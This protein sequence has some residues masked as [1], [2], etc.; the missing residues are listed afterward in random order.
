[1]KL[2]RIIE[3]V[4]CRPWMITPSGYEAI[5]KLIDSKL[6]GADVPDFSPGME[7]GAGYALDANGIGHIQ[8]FGT[9]ANRI[10]MIE[11]ICGGCDYQDLSDSINGCLEDGAK[12]IIFHFDSPGGAAQ[13]CPEV[14]EMIA[15]IDVP[16]V[17]FTDGLCCSAAYFL[18]S[19]C[20]YIVSS[21]SATVGSI[22]VIIPWVDHSQ[23]WAMEGL[24]FDPIFSEGD[25]L[26]TTMHGPSLT[27]E[28]R[29]YLQDEV[30]TVAEGFKSHV[31][32]FRDVD[33]PFLKAGA[34]SGQKALDHNLADM[35]GSYADAYDHLKGLMED[36]GDDDE[37][38]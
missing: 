5:R 30:N 36:S 11:K 18:A 26:K 12:G 13:G 14:A 32:S 16:K 15:S 19:G 23:A 28:Q 34:F 25:S 8:V 21:P 24:K 35:V 27:D 29:Q 3:L 2:A 31:S 1:M 37:G 9:L 17:A 20:D 7:T 33:F 4:N 22:G 6:S 10:G 38:M